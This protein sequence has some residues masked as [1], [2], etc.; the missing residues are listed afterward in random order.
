MIIKQQP[1]E[2]DRALRVIE[3]SRKKW[4]KAHTAMIVFLVT[5][6][7]A[8]VVMFITASV[9]IGRI[10][11]LVGFVLILL[12][13]VADGVGWIG[14]IVCVVIQAVKSQEY[15]NTYKQMLSKYVLQ[16]SFENPLYDPLNGF[17][18][19]EFKA[20]H[21][22]KWRDNFRYR[23]ED[24]IRAKYKGVEFRQAD[25]RITHD[26]GGKNRRIV[27]DVDGR[28]IRIKFHKPIGS[29]IVI[30]TDEREVTLEDKLSK[31]EME[32]MQFNKEFDVF[33]ED[34]HSVFY[35]LTPQFMEYLKKLRAIDNFLFI[36]FDG[37][38]LYVLRSGKG[39]IFEPPHVKYAIDL[40]YEAE[41][42]RKELQE[43]KDIIEVLQL[44]EDK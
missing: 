11:G 2:A 32:D 31:V 1:F 38:D 19:E 3:A 39:G 21:L 40:E 4:E 18:V 15:A 23:S 9:L 6:L 5:I 29:R 22:I 42:N 33:S 34:A 41:K 14:L 24:L 30:A 16:E 35:L 7:V 43:I 44:S 27:V 13:V 20:G 28:L 17:T 36:S 10:H 26:T 37:E 8:F 25:V 12:S